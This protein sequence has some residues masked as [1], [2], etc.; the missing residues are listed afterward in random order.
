M[1][2]AMHVF[3]CCINA[4]NGPLIHEL[5]S[6]GIQADL[7]SQTKAGLVRLSKQ[8][9]TTKHKRLVWV[10]CSRRVSN[11]IQT[12]SQSIAIGTKALS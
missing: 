7:Q 10:Y 1:K 3:L 11:A 9:Y 8:R 4:H 12:T 2:G 5:K 6:L